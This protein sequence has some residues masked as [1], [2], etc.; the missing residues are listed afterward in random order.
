M[1]FNFVTFNFQPTQMQ[2]KTEMSVDFRSK[3]K[4]F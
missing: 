4:I 1:K 2:L 3:T